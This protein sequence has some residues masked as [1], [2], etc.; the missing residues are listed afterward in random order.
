MK[1]Y[2]FIFLG[3]LFRIIK[4]ILSSWLYKKM[5]VQ[6]HPMGCREPTPVLPTTIHPPSIVFILALKTLCASEPSVY[7]PPPSLHLRPLVG[8]DYI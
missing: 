3:R 6:F 4:I 8:S 7:V 1:K 5:M 2:S